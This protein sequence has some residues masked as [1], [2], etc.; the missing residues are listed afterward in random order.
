M[1]WAGMDCVALTVVPESH[2]V[3]LGYYFWEGGEVG[4]GGLFAFCLFSSFLVLGF[5]LA[6]PVSLST[7][8]RVIIL[9]LRWCGTPWGRGGLIR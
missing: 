6:V 5:P 1:L 2:L 3:C 7:V 8:T 9:E 4:S